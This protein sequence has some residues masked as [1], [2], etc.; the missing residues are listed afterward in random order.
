MKDKCEAEGS[1]P[2][3]RKFDLHFELVELLPFPA[4]SAEKTGRR[5]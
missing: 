4:K 3:E 2:L 5:A 1:Q